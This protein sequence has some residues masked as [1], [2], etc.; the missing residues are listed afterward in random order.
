MALAG[1]RIVGHTMLTRSW[2]DTDPA[3]QTGWLGALHDRQIGRAI[4]LIHREP[5]R[6]WTV[7]SLAHELAMSRSAFA[8]RFTELVGESPS[9]YRAR[10]HSWT[11]GLPACLVRVA[12]R[13]VRNREAAVPGEG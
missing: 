9:A 13:P 2:L 4:A 5:A 1:D 8:A 10:D 6:P 11:E 12:L 3:A 7:A